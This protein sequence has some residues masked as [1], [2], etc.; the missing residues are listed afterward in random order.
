MNSWGGQARSLGEKNI[1]HTD[2]LF[3]IHSCPADKQA[4]E[5]DS[6]LTFANR[7]FLFGMYI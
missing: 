5:V 4:Q 7:K 1:T 2:Y 3:F 6:L